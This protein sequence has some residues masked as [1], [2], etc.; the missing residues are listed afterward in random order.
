MDKENGNR[1]RITKGKVAT[2]RVQM[3]RSKGKKRKEKELRKEL[4]AVREEEGELPLPLF[5]L[6]HL[7]IYHFH[8][9][10]SICLLCL[11]FFFSSSHLLSHCR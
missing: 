11:S 1:K 4:V 7:F 10:H 3:G 9:F 2:E 6:F 5:S 8:P